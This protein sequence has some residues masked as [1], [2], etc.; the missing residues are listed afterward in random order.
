MST[1]P[2]SLKTTVDLCIHSV[3]PISIY[4]GP[5]LRLIYNQMYRPILKMKHPQGT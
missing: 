3:F 5:E 2:A 4:Y 1:W